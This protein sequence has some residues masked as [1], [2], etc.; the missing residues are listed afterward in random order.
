MNRV[1]Q[2]TILRYLSVSYGSGHVTAKMAT[3][4]SVDLKLTEA[5]LELCK[6]ATKALEGT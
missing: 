4:L 1:N 6:R 5:Q 3:P 2:V